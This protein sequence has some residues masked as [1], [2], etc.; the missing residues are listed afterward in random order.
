M[1]ALCASD[2]WTSVVAVCRRAPS[3]D[4]L[5]VGDAPAKLTV[6][7][8]TVDKPED[9][10][11]IVQGW[12]GAHVLFNCFGTTRGAA[13]S[14]AEFKRVEVDLTA[15][16]AGARRPSNP[17]VARAP[18]RR[19]RPKAPGAPHAARAPPS[20][21]R[22]AREE[23][24]R[25]PRGGRVGAGRERGAEGAVGEA[26]P[27]ALRADDGPEGGGDA[28][29]LRRRAHHLQAG[30][31]QPDEGRPRVGGLVAD[32]ARPARSPTRRAPPSLPAPAPSA[33]TSPTS[34]TSGSRSSCSRPPWCAT[35]PPR[36]HP[37]TRPRRS[38]RATRASPPRRR[39]KRHSFT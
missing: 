19:T 14:A 10:A 12:S 26:A 9:E 16:A 7:V 13:G 15:R 31:A 24:G 39:R 18:R 22:R 33:R 25:L 38:C 30:H 6:Q 1:R 21:R 28:R 27:A 3:A 32:V 2:Q 5:V 4:E 23:G 35:P 20:L 17:A 11:R 34:S 8:A 36:W 29:R 37:P